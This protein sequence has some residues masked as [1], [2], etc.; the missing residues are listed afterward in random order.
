[1]TEVLAGSTDTETAVGGGVGL[2][3]PPNGGGIVFPPPHAM[4]KIVNAINSGV[5]ARDRLLIF[6]LLA[7]GRVKDVAQGRQVAV[8]SIDGMS[9]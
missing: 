8:Y 6:M 3:P 7:K 4:V 2:P 1:M 5:Q 9:Y